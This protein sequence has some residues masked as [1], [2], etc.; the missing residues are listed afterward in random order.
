[1]RAEKTVK[2]LLHAVTQ[3]SRLTNALTNASIVMMHLRKWSVWWVAPLDDATRQHRLNY[4]LLGHAVLKVNPGKVEKSGLVGCCVASHQ[5][6]GKSTRKCNASVRYSPHSLYAH[7]MCVERMWYH[8]MT[9]RYRMV[10]YV[11]HNI[12]TITRATYASELGH[13]VLLFIYDYS[14]ARALVRK[15]PKVVWHTWPLFN[16]RIFRRIG[17]AVLF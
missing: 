4:F 2:T 10:S 7:T 11:K 5:Q 13:L 17:R 15:M 6:S 8:I 14:R 12:G 3:T 9:K 16:L 1:M